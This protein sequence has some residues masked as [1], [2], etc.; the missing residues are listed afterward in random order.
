MDDRDRAFRKLRRENRMLKLENIEY[1]VL[2]AELIRD[3]CRRSAQ[4]P[5]D[6]SDIPM[7]KQQMAQR[8]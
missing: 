7:T 6:L 3:G 2:L 4:P 5:P 8:H 1:R